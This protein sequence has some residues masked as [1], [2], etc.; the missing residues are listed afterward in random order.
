MFCIVNWLTKIFLTSDINFVMT[1]II[2]KFGISYLLIDFPFYIK[3]DNFYFS[4]V[5]NL[6][7]KEFSLS[8][9]M[10]IF[11]TSAITIL[12]DMVIVISKSLSV[13][14]LRTQFPILLSE[15]G[16]MFFLFLHGQIVLLGFYIST[17]FSFSRFINILGGLFGKVNVFFF[18]S[19]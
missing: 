4:T 16:A 18:S 10:V 1:V 12:K 14:F 11:F 2:L 8:S 17:T 3:K 19:V 9:C 13:N 15:L 5:N 7:I 6:Y